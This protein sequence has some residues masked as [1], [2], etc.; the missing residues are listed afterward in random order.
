M[1]ENPAWREAAHLQKAG[2]VRDGQS[3]RSKGGHLGTGA[4][5]RYGESQKGGRTWERGLR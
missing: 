1:R 3:L 5:I 4:H 2:G